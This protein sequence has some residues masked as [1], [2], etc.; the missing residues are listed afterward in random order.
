M[1]LQATGEVV[2]LDRGFPLVQLPDGTLVRCKHATAL[3]KGE[4]QRAVIGDRVHLS[5]PEKNDK[6]LIVGIEP[7]RSTLIRKDPAER[8]LPQ[9]LAANFDAN[10][11]WLMKLGP[12]FASCSLRPI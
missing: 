2:K 10:W 1:E 6:A 4:K 8:T 5:I 11:C 3:V 7:R 12:R 9:V